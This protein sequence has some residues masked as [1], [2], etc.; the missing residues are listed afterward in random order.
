MQW[1]SSISFFLAGNRRAEICANGR[2]QSGRTRHAAM[3][4]LKAAIQLCSAIKYHVIII[5][6]LAAVFPSSSR[7][8][9]PGR[10]L[11][12]PL[13]RSI[14]KN[15]FI[16]PS[17][18]FCFVLCTCVLFHGPEAPGVKGH[19]MYSNRS[20]GNVTSARGSSVGA[21]KPSGSRKHHPRNHR[22]A[23]GESCRKPRFERRP[24]WPCA[25]PG[26]SDAVSPV[27]TDT[28]QYATNVSPGL[29]H[30]AGLPS[31]FCPVLSVI[32]YHLLDVDVLDKSQGRPFSLRKADGLG[33]FEISPAH[34]TYLSRR[35]SASRPARR[36]YEFRDEI[37]TGTGDA[38]CLGTP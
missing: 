9:R 24:S 6:R 10:L 33:I 30:F 5:G 28:L 15:N 34:R 29:G 14:A 19:R 4:Q 23:C 22:G 32:R 8:P 38:I 35:H 18:S 11:S 26:V 20:R 3:H 2:R 16:V 7:Q 1:R 27:D 31:L 13:P 36:V 12:L 17:L 21:A 37:Q 25:G